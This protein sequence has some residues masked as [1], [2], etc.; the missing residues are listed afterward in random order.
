VERFNLD[1]G[2]RLGCP[3]TYASVDERGWTVQTKQ[4]SLRAKYLVAATAHIASRSIMTHIRG[5]KPLF[6]ETPTSEYLNHFDLVRFLAKRDAK[7]YLPVMW[8][9]KYLVPLYLWKDDR[10][11]PLP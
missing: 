7:N 9:L 2:I 10:P 11:L 4:G 1:D 6:D 3:V 8:R 5:G